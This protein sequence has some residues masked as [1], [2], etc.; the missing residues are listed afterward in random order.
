M[1]HSFGLP[2]LLRALVV[3]VV[4]VAGCG[5]VPG[6]CAPQWG[7]T[8]TWNGADLTVF[9][10]AAYDPDGPGPRTSQL[11]V[12]GSFSLV[13]GTRA[14]LVASWDPAAATWSPLPGTVFGDGLAL[15]AMPGG[16]FVIGG[17]I[18]SVGGVPCGNVA[19]WTGTSW[20]TFGWGVNNLVYGLAALPNG[21]VIAGGMFTQTAGGPANR[22]ARWTTNG[23]QA[24]GTGMDG[25]VYSVAVLPNG[26]VVA[27]GPFTTAGGV[28]VAGLA[29]WDGQAWSALGGPGMAA[30]QT[31]AVL[32]NG[33]LLVGGSE[34]LRYDSAQQW[35]QLGFAANGIVNAITS[36][37]NGDLVVTGSFTT[38]NGAPCSRIAR[39]DGVAWSPLGSGL[40]GT[41]NVNSYALATLPGAGVCVGGRFTQAGGQSASYLAR[42]DGSW[43]AFGTGLDSEV[44]ALA[45]LP[46]GGFAAGGSFRWAGDQA[47]GRVATWNGS[48]WLPMAAGLAG[49]ARALLGLPNGDVVAAG[50]QL[51]FASNLGI[52]RQGSWQPLGAGIPGTVHCLARAG[53]GDVFAGGLFNWAGTGPASNVARWNGTTWAP[54]GS[55][56]DNRV[57]TLCVLQNGDLVAGGIFQNAGALPASRVARW[58]GS[59]WS[60]FGAGP[61]TEVYALA[62]RPNG[63]LIAGGDISGGASRTVQRWNGTAWQTL[64]LGLNQ[65]V[66]ALAVLP[67]GAV[68][69]GGYFEANG[70]TPGRGLAH[71]DGVA[72]G[73]LAGAV[74]GHVR[75]LAVL[76]SGD[77]AVG[78]LF[79]SVGPNFVPVSPHAAVLH[80]PCPA[81]VERLPT[82]CVGPAGPLALN[83][84]TLPLVGGTFRAT[85]RGFAAGA[86][87]IAVTG[88]TSPN[89]PLLQ[90]DPSGLPNCE[91]LA[92]LD[93]VVVMGTPAG[94]ATWSISVPGGVA[95]VGVRVYQQFLQL[96][97]DAQ[98][99]LT[100]SGS[101]ALAVTLGGF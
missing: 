25:P 93:A 51:P 40:D 78:G 96:A 14:P 68:V 88:I 46:G 52:Y 33:D 43:H 56:L 49:N 16:G 54:L 60:A 65:S 42:W 44:L 2:R 23:W 86:A 66:L 9:A 30:V 50:A 73:E 47:L 6:Q 24:L 39:F 18:S 13:G 85:A 57:N 89:V 28:P 100:L 77:L 79:S 61:G 48:S 87:A 5:G 35:H 94:S 45:A 22:I 7:T 17:N 21:D 62:E 82:A 37:P 67:S 1:V 55:G 59:T 74:V 84:D 83:A 70:S 69:A 19:H 63:E 101:N 26:D 12:T 92:S 71:W 10:A 64:G 72:W 32:G 15:C 41:T 29:R 91:L 38:V 81:V 34:L 3:V 99:N 76:D 8:G 27:G 11:A 53:N 98:S 4:V 80:L 97:T 20:Q 58:N 36:A 90:L 31:L 95:F 75:A